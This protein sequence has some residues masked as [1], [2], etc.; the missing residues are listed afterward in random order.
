MTT[1]VA[2]VSMPFSDA[3]A[4]T[5]D[6]AD[7][8]KQILD[9]SPTDQHSWLIGM[10]K[11]LSGWEDISDRTI[12][13]ECKI[14][15]TVWKIWDDLDIVAKKVWE[16]DFYKWA[17]SF[18]KR[19][20]GKEPEKVTIDNKIG[21]FRDWEGEC[22]IK[23]PE[24]IFVPK[25]DVSGKLN[26]KDL[27]S[28]SAWQEVEFDP[29]QWDF[30]K[31]L[32]AR[33]NAKR[34]MLDEEAWTA[35]ADP[36]ATAA[37]LTQAIKESIKTSDDPVVEVKDNGLDFTFFAQ[38][39]LVYVGA[40]GMVVAFARLLSE[41]IDSPIAKRAMD[42]MLNLLGITQTALDDNTIEVQMPIIQTDDDYAGVVISKGA[43]RIGHFNKDE[44]WEIYNTLGIALGELT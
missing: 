26:D 2:L 6:L 20:A 38:N 42:Y 12:W 16:G 25:R 29:S 27:T 9:L 37:D 22:R 3:I 33:A 35:L 23:P 18:S 14:L 1:D 24:H 36:G 28:S 13:T 17:K 21:T 43:E 41:N 11:V 19:R 10:G 34:G 32:I 31:K 4:I 7:Q 30:G 5:K 8:S 15:Y 40:G 39:D 44:M